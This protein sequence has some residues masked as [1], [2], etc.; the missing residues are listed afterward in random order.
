MAQTGGHHH[1]TG[2][3][4][5]S[6]QRV[7]R[8]MDYQLNQEQR[9]TFLLSHQLH[10]TN[11]MLPYEQNSQIVCG[12]PPI[13]EPD[14]T[15]RQNVPLRV[16]LPSYYNWYEELEEEVFERILSGEDEVVLCF[17]KYDSKLNKSIVSHI[18]LGSY[19]V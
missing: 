2:P 17:L 6:R 14:V 12:M 5:W 16:R 7:L 11:N 4:T 13:W 8:Q 18:I 19:S 1:D 9:R 15:Q 3:A 10:F